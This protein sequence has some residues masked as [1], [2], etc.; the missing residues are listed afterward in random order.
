MKR[1]VGQPGTVQWGT[2]ETIRDL[3][4]LSNEGRLNEPGMFRLE[5]SDSRTQGSRVFTSTV[6]AARKD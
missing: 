2:A 5:T 3:V 1:D 4:K 6:A